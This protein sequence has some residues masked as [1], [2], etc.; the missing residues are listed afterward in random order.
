MNHIDSGFALLH[1][2]SGVTSFS[3]LSAI[4]RS[5]RP[6][7]VGHT[8]TL[9]K[10][11]EGLLIAVIGKATKFAPYI[12]ELKK[13]YTATI[14]FG[15]ETDT[16][17]PEGQFVKKNCIL[18]DLQTIKKKTADFIG[19]QMQAPPLFSAVHVNGERAYKLAREGK[20]AN[21]K[22]RQVTISSM[23]IVRYT[24]PFLELSVTCSKGTY[25]RSL[26]RDLGRRCGSCAF[27]VKLMRT[28][29]GNFDVG[30][31]ISP[32]CF[33]PERDIL[34]LEQSIKRMGTIRA[35]SCNPEHIRTFIHGKPINDDLFTEKLDEDGI[36]AVL[37]RETGKFVALLERNRHKF[38]YK[39]VGI[40]E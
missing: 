39:F 17:D 28:K 27:V 19:V 16:L 18:P 36:Y 24:P 31:S 8:G 22:E 11:A 4:K 30:E 21:L 32:E 23:N 12:T 5:V 1:K 2:P 37:N 40:Q 20:T 34:T 33:Q 9:D 3:A 29:I 25:I 13:E 7:K 14:E 10:F 26:A 15:R 38:A 35:I 6:L